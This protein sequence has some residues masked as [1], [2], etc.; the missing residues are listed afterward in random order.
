[1]RRREL[2]LGSTAAVATAGSLPAPAIAQGIKE[3]KMVTGW[4]PNMA[5]PQT[6][7]ERLAQ[8]IT[9]MSDGRLK[10]MVYPAGSLVRPLEVFDA[11]ADGVANM[12]HSNDQYFEAKSPALNFFCAVPYGMTADELYSW[13]DFSGGQR[14]WDE[15]S[16]PFN[17][18]PLSC[19]NTGAQMGGWFRREISRPEDFKGLRYRMA[20]LGADVLRRLGATVVTTPGGEIITALKSGAIDAA[21]WV[22]PWLDID[23][24]LNKA[25]DY[26]YYPGFH[27]PGTNNTLGIN[28]TLWDG[29]AP[30][31]RALIEAA[32]Q[33]E[34]TR[35]LAEFNA[36][37]AK[38]LKLLRADERIK[39]LRFSDE[40]IRTFGKLTKEVLADTAAKDPLTRRVYDSYMAFLAGVMDW[41]ELSDTGYRDTRRLALA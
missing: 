22:G 19:M 9:A 41:G 1:M 11:V 3:L 6:S 14:L 26:Y 17:I 39:I 13:I 24:G 29:L 16:A 8:S 40:L 38:A 5:G 28:K 23:M 25:A 4:P 34:V 7:A 2:L 37:N 10:V 27:E 35:S 21:E 32:A 33:A 20:G 18:K 31:E 30:S 36:E 12:Y 15:V